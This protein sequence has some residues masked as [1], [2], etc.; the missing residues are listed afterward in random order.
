LYFLWISRLIKD[1]FPLLEI[2]YLTSRFYSSLKRTQLSYNSKCLDQGD[3]GYKRIS[4][5][6]FG[7]WTIKLLH[8]RH[9]RTIEPSDFSDYRTITLTSMRYVKNIV[10]SMIVDNVLTSRFYS[11]LKRTQ[12][13]YNS[14]CLDQGDDGYKR[15]SALTTISFKHIFLRFENV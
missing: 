10:D 13:S 8:Y 6:L 15:I 11:S 14:K 3:D 12:L 4:A 5:L 7:F 1:G 2:G 9:L